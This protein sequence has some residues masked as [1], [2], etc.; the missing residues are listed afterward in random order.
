MPSFSARL[1][2]HTE[3]RARTDGQQRII[4][5]SRKKVVYRRAGWGT[6]VLLSLDLGLRR[7]APDGADA[8]SPAGSKQSNKL[9]CARLRRLVVGHATAASND[10][11]AVPDASARGSNQ[12]PRCCCSAASSSGQKTP[13]WVNARMVSMSRA[14]TPVMTSAGRG[15]VHHAP[16]SWSNSLRDG[17]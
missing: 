17:L 16:W 14:T 13:L 8:A 4:V 11:S 10:G 6:S 7:P 15:W 9:R 2:H 3:H 5:A 1:V 12:P